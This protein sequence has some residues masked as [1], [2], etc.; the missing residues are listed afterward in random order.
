M[1]DK[2]KW[3]EGNKVEEKR[4]S[5]TKRMTIDVGRRVGK[6]GKAEQ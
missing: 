2:K 3:K 4:E 5:K 1:G 6:C